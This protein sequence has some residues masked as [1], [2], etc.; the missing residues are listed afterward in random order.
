MNAGC[1]TIMDFYKRT[2]G[3]SV[4][5]L[6][7]ALLVILHSTFIAIPFQT[8]LN[9]DSKPFAE[10]AK[11]KKEY[12]YVIALWELVETVP[13]LF[14]KIANYKRMHKILTKPL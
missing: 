3:I 2:N 10:M 6:T 9:S 12:G 1:S 11:N 4:S 8:S 5:S 14:Q 13:T 7:C